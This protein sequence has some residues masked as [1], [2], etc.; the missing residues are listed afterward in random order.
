NNIGVEY[1]YIRQPEKV[2]WLQERMEQ[3]RNTPSFTIEEKKEF[4]MKLDQAVVFEKFLGKKFL[5]QKRFSIEG[6]ETLIPALDWIIEHGAKVHDIKD[7][8]IGMAH[9]GRLNVLANT[10]NKTYESIFAEFEGRD[11]EDALVEGDVKYHMGYS[12]CVITDSGKGVTLTLSPNPS[13]L[14]SVDPV[15]QGIA[16]AII[17]EDHAFDSKKVVPV[18]IHGDAAIAGQG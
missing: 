14:E 5:G 11:Y 13:H 7:V 8:V 10:L 17:E 6:V 18:L 4:L 16:R 3:A 9:R 1:R 2:K 15:V 12:S